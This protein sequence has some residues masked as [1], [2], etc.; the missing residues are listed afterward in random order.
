MKRTKSTMKGCF[1]LK[2]LTPFNIKMGASILLLEKCFYTDTKTVKQKSIVGIK[3]ILGE[4]HWPPFDKVCL[5][6]KI[7]LSADSTKC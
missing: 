4:R 2:M 5:M 6:Y 3:N 7:L 1:K